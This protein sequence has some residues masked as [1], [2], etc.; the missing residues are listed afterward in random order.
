MELTV[1][2]CH[3]FIQGFGSPSSVAGEL[4]FF[5]AV[6]SCES[7]STLR[8]GLMLDYVRKTVSDADMTMDLYYASYTIV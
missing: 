7:T 2:E 3:L 5:C 1:D 4:H 6:N 8:Q